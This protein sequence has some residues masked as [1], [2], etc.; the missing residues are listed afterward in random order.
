MMVGNRYRDPERFGLLQEKIE[1]LQAE[2]DAIKNGDVVVVPRV[3]TN[4][5]IEAGNRAISFPRHLLTSEIA[6]DAYKAMIAA[7]EQK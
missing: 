5:M 7:Q 2:L 6:I 3:P 4:K 1:R